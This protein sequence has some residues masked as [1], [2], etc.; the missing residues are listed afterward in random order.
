MCTLQFLG[1]IRV[2]LTGYLDIFT[3]YTVPW[4]D[5]REKF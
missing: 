3:L 4:I 5:E 2:V 1:Y